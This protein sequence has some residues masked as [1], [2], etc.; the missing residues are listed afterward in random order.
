VANSSKKY[1]HYHRV[2]TQ[3]WQDYF[4]EVLNNWK[5]AK[6]RQ[7]R[8]DAIDSWVTADLKASD[9]IWDAFNDK[10]SGIYPGAASDAAW[11]AC[12]Q[13]DAD[14]LEAYKSMSQGSAR[15]AV[16]IYLYGVN[17]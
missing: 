13:A 17:T 7:A 8:A 15:I 2:Y 14:M 6:C 11:Y 3:I 12:K 4:A 5:N 16:F 1:N 10:F 9:M